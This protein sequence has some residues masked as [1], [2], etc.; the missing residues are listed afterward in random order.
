MLRERKE[1]LDI[2]VVQAS[3]QYQR[4][5]VSWRWKS[6]RIFGIFGGESGRG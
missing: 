1:L 5:L 6:G 3:L 2:L 4:K